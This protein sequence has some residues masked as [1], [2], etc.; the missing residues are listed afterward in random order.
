MKAK[1]GLIKTG[2]SDFDTTKIYNFKLTPCN[3]GHSMTYLET[4]KGNLKDLYARC[5]E[6]VEGLKSIFPL[7]D[8]SV[9]IENSTFD[10]YVLYVPSAG[11][12]D[13][14]GNLLLNFNYQKNNDTNRPSN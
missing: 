9:L 12:L 11:I 6:I 8:F 3:E 13:K 5:N 1:E 14:N 7:G 2:F 10:N 4:C